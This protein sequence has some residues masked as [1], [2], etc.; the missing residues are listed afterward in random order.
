MV[1]GKQYVEVANYDGTFE[2]YEEVVVEELR[3]IHPSIGNHVMAECPYRDANGKT[4]FSVFVDGGVE[5]HAFQRIQLP[6]M[7]AQGNYSYWGFREGSW[8]LVING[9]KG[10]SRKQPFGPSHATHTPIYSSPDGQLLW[11][12]SYSYGP[13]TP[14]TGKRLAPDTC[15]LLRNGIV[16]KEILH[17]GRY[18]EAMRADGERF[19]QIDQVPW[20]N[21]VI[22]VQMHKNTYLLQSGKMY[23][24]FPTPGMQNTAFFNTLSKREQKEYEQMQYKQHHVAT[25]R[26]LEYDGLSNG[27]FYFVQDQG[28]RYLVVYNHQQFTF[29]KTE[30]TFILNS[31]QLREGVFSFLVRQGNGIYRIVSN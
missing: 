4:V 28:D 12:Y 29:S 11:Q 10:E 7:D 22:M 27:D 1:V 8:S 3:M 14:E 23:G 18:Y 16:V 17:E 30:G 5:P 26:L 9:E 21:Q 15:R 24:P 6:V 25:N 19:G 2:N 31:C 20:I 13:R